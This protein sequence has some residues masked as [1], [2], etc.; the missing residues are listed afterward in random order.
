MSIIIGG[1]VDQGDPLLPGNMA[2]V[3]T[4]MKPAGCTGEV[5]GELRGCCDS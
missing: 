4:K 5:E 3:A 2:T 1:G